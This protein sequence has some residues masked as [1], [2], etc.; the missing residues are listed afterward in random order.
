[1]LKIKIPFAI[2]QANIRI[3]ND[4]SKKKKSR[5]GKMARAFFLIKVEVY[6][7]S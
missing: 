3:K 5:Y 2:M 1:M 7:E 6:D 4:Y